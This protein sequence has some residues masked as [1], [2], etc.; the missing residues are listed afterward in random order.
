MEIQPILLHKYRLQI[1]DLMNY[2]K[3][4]ENVRGM[5][6]YDIPLVNRPLWPF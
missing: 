2:A 6:G 3:L 1:K 5:L 4:V